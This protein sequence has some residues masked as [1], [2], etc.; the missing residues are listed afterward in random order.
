[1]L[2]FRLFYH[3]LEGMTKLLKKVPFI[4]YFFITLGAIIMALSIGVFL[5]DVRV[6]PGEG[7]RRRI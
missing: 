2:N 3:W 7:L 5:V 1:M 4:Y 6:V